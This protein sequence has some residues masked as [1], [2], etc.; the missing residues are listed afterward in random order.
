MPESRPVLAVDIGGTKMAAGVVEPGGRLITWDKTPTPHDLDAEPLWRTLD[1]LITRV[2]EAAGIAGPADL[3]GVG[4]GC[5]GPMQWPAGLVSP[6]NIP[7]WREFPLRRRLA[8][9]FG[10][11]PVRVHNDAICMTAAEHWRGA[12]RG[13]RNVLGIVVST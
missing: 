13:R 6:L 3:A 12:G 4:C 9:R 8:A 10:G 7:G 5:G 2:L 11:I 1:T